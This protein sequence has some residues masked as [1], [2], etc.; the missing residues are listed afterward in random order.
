M[1]SRIE[2]KQV[3][4][5]VGVKQRFSNVNGLGESV[6]KMWSETP[7]EIALLLRAFTCYVATASC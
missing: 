4:T 7:Q 6:G 1:N 3:F 5:I 2:Q